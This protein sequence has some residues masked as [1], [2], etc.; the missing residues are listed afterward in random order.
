MGL[1]NFSGEDGNGFNYRIGASKSGKALSTNSNI[2]LDLLVGL[3]QRSAGKEKQRV[4]SSETGKRL[5]KLMKPK[6]A[7][8]NGI[9]SAV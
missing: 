2:I 9:N 8:N 7:D 1:A 3:K 6:P 5:M 4:I